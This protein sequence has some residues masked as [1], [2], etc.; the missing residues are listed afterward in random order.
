VRNEIICPHCGEHDA[1]S[2]SNAR[3]TATVLGAL[4]GAALVV[5]RIAG[6]TPTALPA[7][8]LAGALIGLLWGAKAGL[9]IGDRIDET[10]PRMHRCRA[11]GGE[12]EI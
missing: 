9:F 6:G 2:S 3:S 1:E 12:F 4:S 10:F 5:L 8:L 11:C 7:T